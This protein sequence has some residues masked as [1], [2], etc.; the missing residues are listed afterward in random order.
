MG[1][2]TK[3]YLIRAIHEWCTDSG[4]RAYIAV[5]VD[6]R[7]V[8]PR[9]F[10]RGGEIV[11]NVSPA[12]TNRLQLGND[13]IE[14]EARF[15]G[16]ARAVSIPIDNVSAIYAQETG[17][18]MAFE[19][20]KP[21][22]L[23]PGQGPEDA[24]DSPVAAGPGAEPQS[25]ETSAPAPRRAGGR[26]KLRAVPSPSEAP[27]EA[28]EKG[29]RTEASGA[30]EAAEAPADPAGPGERES[31]S[32][33][34]AEDVK[35]PSSAA[36]PA[37][38]RRKPA[39]RA[40]PAPNAATS[41]A[42]TKQDGESDSPEAG[43]GET[44]PAEKSTP[45]A[46]R[47]RATRARKP[48]NEAPSKDAGDPANAGSGAAASERSDAAAAPPPVDEPPRPPRRGPPKLTRVK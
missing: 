26:P 18:G 12:A 10:V 48:K 25:D 47:A 16:V 15:G 23:E 7:T 28:D 22:A 29:T 30:S 39:T 27:S 45:K 34:V 21:L 38:R 35:E 19:V 33:P 17:Q 36:A 6:S 41:D 40:K 4:Y 1:L 8:V 32:T 37:G 31:A 11:L 20:P 46:P 43:A 2:S 9:E 13:L 44:A 24:P 42:P 14:F 5:S 3:P